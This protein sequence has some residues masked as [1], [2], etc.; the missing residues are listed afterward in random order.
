MKVQKRGSEL[1]K[2]IFVTIFL[3]LIIISIYYNFTRKGE[4]AATPSISST[5]IQQ[6][7]IIQG[8]VDSNSTSTTPSRFPFPYPENWFWLWSERDTYLWTRSAYIDT[9]KDV[10]GSPV[11]IALVYREIRPNLVIKSFSWYCHV[12]KTNSEEVCTSKTTFDRSVEGIGYQFHSFSTATYFICQLPPDTDHKDVRAVSFSSD[13]C[14]SARH[15]P[16]VLIKPREKVKKKVLGICLHKA[17][18]EVKEPQPIVEYIEIHRLLGVEIFTVYIQSVSKE[19]RDILN[20]YSK[21][22]IVEIVEWNIKISTKVIRDF[23]QVGVIHD[24][25][26]RNQDRVEYL[27]FSDFDEVFVPLHDGTLDKLL[28]RLDQPNYASFRF[29]HV[30]MHNTPAL[31]KQV[32]KF[33]CSKV[34][35]PLYFQRYKRS[36]FNDSSAYNG[37]TLG[38]KAKIFVKPKGIVVMGRHSMHLRDTHKFAPGYKELTVPGKSGLFFHYRKTLQPGLEHRELVQE[39]ALAKYQDELIRRLNKRLCQN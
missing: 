3:S 18:F 14:Q 31:V 23:G 1:K 34:R 11:I 37:A 2:F 30:F 12:M 4:T 15:S 9:R 5:I 17:L 39:T 38:S 33:N 16:F 24:C 13:S 10:Y 25:L 7:I 27:G 35:L 26:L 22:G 32:S 36:D 29:L 28:K 21:E 6:Y 8:N 19:I 20:K